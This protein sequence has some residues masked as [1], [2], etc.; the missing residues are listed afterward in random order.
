MQK[1]MVKDNFKMSSNCGVNIISTA[2]HKTQLQI[3]NVLRG[4]T[5]IP[6]V[7]VTQEKNKDSI[8]K[9]YISHDQVYVPDF[10]YEW[11]HVKNH[12]RVYI[13]VATRDNGKE[14]SSYCICTISSRLAASGF[15]VFYQFLLK[16]KA[17]NRL[18]A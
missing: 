3:L 1:A 12:Y 9:I 11:C 6:R 4:L 13:C 5:D 18:A 8:K 16:H 17:N 15:S 14:K 10:I 7:T 2:Y